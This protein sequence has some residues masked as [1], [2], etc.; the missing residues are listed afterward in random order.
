MLELNRA[1]IPPLRAVRQLQRFCDVIQKTNLHRKRDFALS[2]TPQ[3]L[4]PALRIA[5]G[6]LI[7]LTLYFCYFSNL[8]VIGFLGPDEPRYAWIARDM[9]ETGDWITPRLYGR[10]WFEKP[11]L[12]YWG[13][14][15]FFKLMPD[16]PEIAG[17]LPS[18][19]SAL[20]ATLALAWL[21]W[22]TY[23]EECARWLLLLLPTSIGMIGFSHACATDM[24]FA[25]MLTVSLVWA[26]VILGLVPASE[27][28]PILPRT[29]WLALLLFAFFLGLAVLAKGPAAI[30][31]IGGAAFFWALSTKRW[32]D[33]FRLLHP[34]AIAVFLLTALP[35]YIL[36]AR[37]NPDFFR[38]F[39]IEHNFKRFLSPEFQHIQ[40]FW[41]YV[42]VLFVALAPWT[43]VGLVGVTNR[44]LRFIRFRAASPFT[45]LIFSWTTF[46]LVF[47]SLSKS[48]LP[49]YVLP[50]VPAAVLA[51]GAVCSAETLLSRRVKGFL[52]ALTSFLFFSAFAFLCYR[53]RSPV[54]LHADQLGYRQTAAILVA[55]WFLGITTL[56]LATS[57][58]TRKNSAAEFSFLAAGILAFTF[59]IGSSKSLA[60]RTQLNM[61]SGKALVGAAA[62]LSSAQFRLAGFRRDYRYGLSFY[63]HREVIEWKD[64]P[65]RN[66]FV[67]TDGVSCKQLNTRDDCSNRWENLDQEGNWAL[68]EITQ[69]DSLGG[70]GSGRQPN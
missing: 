58:A 68:L 19:I 47:F 17:R 38:V 56:L 70:T 10:P 23:G 6:I 24:P 53:L 35:W 29:P 26:A 61:A 62:E 5:W 43:L 27:N 45:V 63:L 25:G 31:L 3:L 44:S 57:F 65:I 33:V 28:T 15:I 48:K 36:C 52:L 4:S 34:A 20:L 46:C 22:R 37:R 11:P 18:A 42:P 51:I 32:R 59:L 14:A 67:L 8:D 2:T 41:F 12:L 69:A 16:K 54:S 55:S 64:D 7:V 50:A 60:D 21:A 9:A 49:G 30:I 40:P 13:G 39:I 1:G 66:G